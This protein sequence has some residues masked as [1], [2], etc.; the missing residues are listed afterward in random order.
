VEL[1]IFSRT[2]SRP[3]LLLPL[4]THS[5]FQGTLYNLTSHTPDLGRLYRGSA[6]CSSR[7]R[8][9]RYKEQALNHGSFKSGGNQLIRYRLFKYISRQEQGS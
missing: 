5:S 8:R 4:S 6:A 2:L 9:D 7:R 1:H 3:R